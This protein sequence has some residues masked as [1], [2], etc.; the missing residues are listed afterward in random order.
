M[1]PVQRLEAGIHAF[2][3]P[4]GAKTGLSCELGHLVTSAPFCTV[5]NISLLI[6]RRGLTD[7]EKKIQRCPVVTF[8][9][10][11]YT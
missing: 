2:L 3:I 5:I 4:D 11:R 10:Y 7:T 8:P 9:Q 6:V 1:D